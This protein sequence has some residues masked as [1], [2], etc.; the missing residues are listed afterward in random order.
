MQEKVFNVQ[1]M[2]CKH[3]VMTVTEAVTEIEGVKS[4]SVNLEDKS[5]TVQFEDS[6]SAEEIINAINEEGFKAS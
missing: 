1:G 3:C 6:V 5:V 4:C 2:K